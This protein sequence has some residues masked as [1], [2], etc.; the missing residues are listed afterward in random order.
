MT[1]SSLKCLVCFNLSNLV[2][3]LYILEPVSLSQFE[4]KCLEQCSFSWSKENIFLY[5]ILAKHSKRAFWMRYGEPVWKTA[6]VPV[7]GLSAKFLNWVC[8]H[9]WT[10]HIVTIG[11]GINPRSSEGLTHRSVSNHMNHRPEVRC[12]GLC[13]QGGADKWV[14]TVLQLWASGKLDV[15]KLCYHNFIEYF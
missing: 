2:S 13:T 5:R 14:W 3:K 15:R 9:L 8:V 11:K 12:W 1:V 7:L 10:W 6:V 4:S